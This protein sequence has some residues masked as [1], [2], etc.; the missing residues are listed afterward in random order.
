MATGDHGGDARLIERR[1]EDLE[2]AE[3][4]LIRQGTDYEKRITRLEINYE[5]FKEKAS[6]FVTRQ[7]FTPIRMIVYGL[8][9][10][11]LTGLLS[12]IL[13]RLFAK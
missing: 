1:I 8:A 2:G 10:T 11:A 4:V 13:A 12:A 5:N 7:E 3:E 6:E 9:A